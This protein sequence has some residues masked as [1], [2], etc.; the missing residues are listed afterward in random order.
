MPFDFS[1]WF[2]RR[3]IVSLHKVHRTIRVLYCGTEYH[4]SCPLVA[5]LDWWTHV[6]YLKVLEETAT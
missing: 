5:F 3:R 1:P 6:F 4:Q 2:F